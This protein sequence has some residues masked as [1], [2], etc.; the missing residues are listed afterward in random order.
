L[1][2]DPQWPS[3]IGELRDHLMDLAVEL[4]RPPSKKELKDRFDQRLPLYQVRPSEFS[5]LLKAAGLSWLKRGKRDP[6][7]VSLR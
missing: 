6:G 3:Q 1:L 7:P 5:T 4:Q 2:N